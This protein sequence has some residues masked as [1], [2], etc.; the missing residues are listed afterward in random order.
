MDLS[1]VKKHRQAFGWSLK[2]LADQLGVSRQALH[3]YEQGL[4][5]P[6]EDVWIKLREV[7]GLPGTIVDYWGRTAAKTKNKRYTDQSV[8]SISGCQEKPVSKGMC[9]KHYQKHRYHTKTKER[10]KIKHAF[11]TD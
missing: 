8:C 3:A 6:R 7:L 4:Y 11:W 5:P 10:N 1:D 9:S 2:E